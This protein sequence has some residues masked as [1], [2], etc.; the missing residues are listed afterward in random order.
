MG[1]DPTLGRRS[2]SSRAAVRVAHGTRVPVGGSGGTGV[3]ECHVTL[4]PT[5]QG[6]RAASGRIRR[7]REKSHQSPRGHVSVPATFHSTD[8][9]YQGNKNAGAYPGVAP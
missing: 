2:G 9:L 3:P 4:Q 8:Q 6:S 7:S 5:E 1:E